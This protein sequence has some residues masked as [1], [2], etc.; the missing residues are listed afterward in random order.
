MEESI[1]DQIASHPVVFVYGDGGC[2]KS[3]AVAEYLRSVCERQLVWSELATS[4]TEPAIVQGINRVRLPG[5]PGGGSDHSLFDL[6]ARLNVANRDGRPMWTI[7]LDGVDEAPGNRAEI[8]HLINECW[9]EGNVE[10]SPASLLV[11]C[12]SPAAGDRAKGQLVSDWIGTPEPDLVQGVGFVYVPEFIDQHLAQAAILLNGLPEQRIINSLDPNFGS[13]SR[14]L[15]DTETI[16]DEIIQALRHPVV[17]GGYASLS[18]AGREGVLAGDPTSLATLAEQ[19]LTRFLLRCHAR[20]MW[21]DELMVEKGLT[22]AARSIT[23][24]PPYSIED[25][26]QGCEPF[27]GAAEARSLYSEALSYGLV[28]RDAVANWRWGHR[29][30][31]DYMATR[32]NARS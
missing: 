23:V 3:L 7:D 6:R 30:V 20:R 18:E 28:R 1:R 24:A 32:S 9:A 11:T 19:L 15:P 27:L 8:R 16:S 10:R 4:A 31:V 5:S 12:R 17:W 25:W 21:S 2:G 26:E 13:W 22:A 29:F 14:Q